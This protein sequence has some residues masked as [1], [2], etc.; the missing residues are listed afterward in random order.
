MLQHLHK[1]YTQTVGSETKTHIRVYTVILAIFWIAIFI[2]SSVIMAL[3]LNKKCDVNENINLLSEN[4]FYSM[5]NS[6]KFNDDPRQIDDKDTN[7]SLVSNWLMY[8]ATIIFHS[9]LMILGVITLLWVYGTSKHIH[10]NRIVIV[11]VILYNLTILGYM[12]SYSIIFIDP[13]Y[14]ILTYFHLV[15]DIVIDDGVYNSYTLTLKI[16]TIA[17]ASLLG[18]Q[19]IVQLMLFL[20]IYNHKKNEQTLMGLINSTY[21]DDELELTDVEDNNIQSY[22]HS[23]IQVQQVPVY[24]QSHTHSDIQPNMHYNIQTVSCDYVP[25]QTHYTSNYNYPGYITIPTA[26]HL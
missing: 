26:P 14:S 5:I 16:L 4:C 13:F 15:G 9:V 12:L 17:N 19:C 8:H 18:F 3:T 2:V 22:N 25:L 7:L 1:N 23:N 6:N 24:M 21:V 20:T 11:L 10:E